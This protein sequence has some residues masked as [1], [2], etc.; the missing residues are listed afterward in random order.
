MLAAVLAG[1]LVVGPFS[2]V[3]LRNL[4]DTPRL[5]RNVLRSVSGKELLAVGRGMAVVERDGRRVVVTQQG[6]RASLTRELTPGRY[7]IEVEANA[8]DDGTDSFWLQLDGKRVG[9]PFSLPVGVFGTR[10]TA[11]KVEK[12]GRH[13]LGI[14]LREAPGVVLRKLTWFRLEVK[15][16][17]PPLRKELAGRHPRLLFTTADLPELRKRADSVAGKRFYKPAGVLTRKPPP[18]RPG[19]RN[20]GAFRSLGRYAF[21]QLLVPDPAKLKAILNWLEMATT[22]PHCGADLDAE[23][24]TEGIALTYDWLYDQI[25]ADLR[26]R[27]RDTI[28]RQ[29]RH[30]FEATLNGSAGGGLSFQQ[31]HFWYSHLALALGAAAVCGEVPEAE[32]WLAWAWDGYERIALSFSPDGGFHEGPSYWDFSLPTL[33]LYTDLYE[34]CTGLHIPAGDDGLRG[35]AEFRFH[36]LYPGLEHSATL[37]DTRVPLGRPPRRLLLWQAKRFKDAEAQGMAARLL[38]RPES[39]C[40][41]LLWLDESLPTPAPEKTLPLAR[42]Y[43]DVE[44]VFARTDWTPDATYVAFVCRPLGGHKWADL[45]DKFGLG[46]TGHNHP[47]QNHFMLFAYGAVLADDPGYTYEKRTRNHNT[48][49]VDGRGQYGDGETWPRPTPGRAHL[50]AFGTQ[51][52]VTLMVGEAASAYPKEL[53]LTRFQRTLVLAGRNLVVVC[54]RLA[55]RKKHTFSW[56]LHHHGRTTAAGTT[57]TIVRGPARLTVEPLLPPGVKVSESTYRPLFIHPTRDL[58]PKEP[59]LHLIELMTGPVKRT[60][61]L[62]P[63]LVG[64]AGDPIPHVSHTSTPAADLVRLGETVVAINRGEGEM[65]LTTPWGETLH[66]PA[67]A[68]VARVHDGKRQVVV[69]TPVR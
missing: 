61:F 32:S 20:G 50:I 48:I 14:V 38:T 52:D 43:P 30:V 15:A 11:V 2:G 28:A 17:R 10:S 54:D 42:Y 5:T 51:G 33:Y 31:N 22:Y 45:C 34:W 66:S 37:E 35:Q 57:R 7:G 59:D 53:G 41:N 13:T 27:V 26:V 29:T 47:E 8:P 40:W 68:L 36:H 58:T 25:P 67:P 62:V 69:A 39:T 46:G 1:T 55:A 49:L 64:R 3:S 65:S 56:L 9:P 4:T 63:L 6:F 21:S 19:R 60:T 18:F 23:Y 44:T 16:P 24:F 12:S